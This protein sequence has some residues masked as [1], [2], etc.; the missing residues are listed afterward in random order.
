MVQVCTVCV[1][2]VSPVGETMMKLSR[3]SIMLRMVQMCTVHVFDV[4]PP[5]WDTMMKLSGVSIVLRMVPVC[6]GCVLVMCPVW[7]TLR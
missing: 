1:L 3:V 4:S 5:R 6:T 2:N 7:E